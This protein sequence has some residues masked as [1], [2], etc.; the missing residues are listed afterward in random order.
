VSGRSWVQ[1]PPGTFFPLEKMYSKIIN[2]HSR[3]DRWDRMKAFVDEEWNK[4][5]KLSRFEAY[6]LTKHEARDLVTPKVFESCLDVWPR[7]SDE[8]LKGLGSIGCYY[9]HYRAWHEFIS[10]EH[11]IALILED[12]LDPTQA[13]LLALNVK[14][15]MQRQPHWDIALLGWVGTLYDPKKGF[16]G[17]HAYM[18]TKQAAYHLVEDALPMTK[19]VDYYLN[20][21]I[22]NGRL[23]MI[24][25]PHHQRLRQA[26]SPSNIY[27]PTYL[28]LAC[29]GMV[30][31]SVAFVTLKYFETKRRL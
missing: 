13:R 24:H 10:S 1:S 2:L 23:R 8:Q 20:D 7:T 27:T 17:A 12:D 22:R 16:V 26:Y 25:V 9:S 31:F 6:S 18:L 11:S 19:Q 21:S 5:F 3:P 15:C 28:H 30:V 14:Y 4:E 29:I